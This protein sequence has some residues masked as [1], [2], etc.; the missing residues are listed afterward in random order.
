MQERGLLHGGLLVEVTDKAMG[1]GRGGGRDCTDHSYHTRD[2]GAARLEGCQDQ[3]LGQWDP[4][5]GLC[6]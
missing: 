6:W 1:L 4:S 5:G 2:W 3:R